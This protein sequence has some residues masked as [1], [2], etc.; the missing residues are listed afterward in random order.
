MATSPHERELGGIQA[1]LGAIE[2]KML[3]SE[4]DTD[5]HRHAVRGEIKEIDGKV[6]ALR[7][8]MRDGFQEIRDVMSQQKG[9]MKM[10]V[11]LSGM[12]GA[13]AGVFAKPLAVLLGLMK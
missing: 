2:N 9:A 4:E 7:D 12:F 1:R 11:A 6:D 13:G 8:E 5:R 3:D 10:L